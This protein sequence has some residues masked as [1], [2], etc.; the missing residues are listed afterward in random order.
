MAIGVKNIKNMWLVIKNSA[1]LGWQLEANW[2][3]PFSF[4]IFSMIR[5]LSSILII[6]FMFRFALGERFSDE[7]FNFFFIGNVLYLYVYNILFGVSQVVFE[8][9]EHYEVIKYIYISP[10]NW[11]VYFMGRGLARFIIATI[12]VAVS[13]VFGMFFLPLKI[14]IIP[15]A[16]LPLAASFFLGVFSVFSLGIIMCS[17]TLVMARHGNMMAESVSGIFFIA[18]G[19]IFPIKTLPESVQAL[20]VN[21]PISY[22]F[23]ITR[24]LLQG[25]ACSSDTVWLGRTTGSLFYSLSISTIVLFFASILTFAY[26]SALARSKGIIDRTTSY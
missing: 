19:T 9:R 13:I 15:A 25:V 10:V 4:I 8:D 7:M 14:S 3:E 11:Y 20:A 21:I 24:R 1:W 26:L 22:W 17:L 23:E 16:I 2:A 6:T 18:C 5:P 12:S